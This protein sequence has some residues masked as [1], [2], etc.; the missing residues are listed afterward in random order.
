MRLSHRYVM[1]VLL[2]KNDHCRNIDPFFIGNG[3]LRIY[4]RSL[5]NFVTAAVEAAENDVDLFKIEF[6][7]V[8]GGK[9]TR[10]IRAPAIKLEFASVQIL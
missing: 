3:L 6:A 2:R 1:I 4:Q 8:G 7:G 10:L 9:N 5:V